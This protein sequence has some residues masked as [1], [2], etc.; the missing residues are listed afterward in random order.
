LGGT[1]STHGS[2]EKWIKEFGGEPEKRRPLG[3]RKRR[4]GDNIE[5]GFKEV[6]WK[7]IDWI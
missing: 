3:R 7:G 4:M 2:E 1:C 5:I 6:A